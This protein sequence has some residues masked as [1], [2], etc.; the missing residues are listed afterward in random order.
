[1]TAPCICTITSWL[2]RSETGPGATRPFPPQVQMRRMC[3]PSKVPRTRAA[4]LKNGCEGPRWSRVSEKDGAAAQEGAKAQGAAVQGSSE[5]PEGAVGHWLGL[6]DRR[7]RHPL[8]APRTLAPTPGL[9]KPTRAVLQ[10]TLE[11]AASFCQVNLRGALLCKVRSRARI[12]ISGG[13]SS[14]VTAIGFGIASATAAR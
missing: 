7:D 6:R 13:E 8:R 2:L 10:R 4:A 12:A 9:P 1:M 11:M 14:R 5:N 3:L